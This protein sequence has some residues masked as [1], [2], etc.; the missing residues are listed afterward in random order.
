MQLLIIIINDNIQDSCNIRSYN[1]GFYT[2][3]GHVINALGATLYDNTNN[4]YIYLNNSEE[5]IKQLQES[6]NTNLDIND[7]NILEVI[8]D[9]NYNYNTLENKNIQLRNKQKQICN[10]IKVELD[11][12]KI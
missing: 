7:S 3:F 10:A 5:L 11:K 8:Q 12:L 9:A 6:V 2:N 1:I 4:F